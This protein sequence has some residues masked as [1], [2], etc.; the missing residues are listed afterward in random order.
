MSDEERHGVVA[1]DVDRLANSGL[2]AI[3]A[4]VG[5]AYATRASDGSPRVDDSHGA[6]AMDT[7]H[8]VHNEPERDRRNPTLEGAHHRETAAM[9]EAPDRGS[10]AI[11]PS[12]DLRSRPTLTVGTYG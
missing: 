6:Q 2:G 9:G 8:G 1:I 12:L 4:V 3:P 11:E 7:D 5:V 10:Q